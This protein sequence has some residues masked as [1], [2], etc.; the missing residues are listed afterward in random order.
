ME[1]SSNHKDTNNGSDKQRQTMPVESKTRVSVM[2]AVELHVHDC[3]AGFVILILLSLNLAADAVH[4]LNILHPTHPWPNE[5]SACQTCTLSWNI[6]KETESN[7]H[8]MM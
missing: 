2:M 7:M 4:V 3:Y 5:K 1:A 8:N 6:N